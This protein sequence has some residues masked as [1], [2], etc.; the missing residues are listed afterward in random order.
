[1][2]WDYLLTSAYNLTTSFL[3]FD[4]VHMV[5]EASNVLNCCINFSKNGELEL[6]ALQSFLEKF[7]ERADIHVISIGCDNDLQGVQQ[8]YPWIPQYCEK[9]PNHKVQISLFDPWFYIVNPLANGEDREFHPFTYKIP[10][11]QFVSL[12][13]LG[14]WQR[15]G[16]GNV[17]KHLNYNIEV[18]VY[19]SFPDWGFETFGRLFIQKYLAPTILKHIVSNNKVIISMHTGDA[20]I[21]NNLKEMYDVLEEKLNIDDLKDH[22]ILFGENDADLSGNMKILQYYNGSEHTLED[23]PA[24]NIFGESSDQVS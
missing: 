10:D 2:L 22:L 9:N 12:V 11:P 3:S 8:V 14:E 4:G 20:W 18:S 17:Y 24:V 23:I 6:E 16:Q 21:S 1:M 13:T 15:S 7:S 5:R 19:K